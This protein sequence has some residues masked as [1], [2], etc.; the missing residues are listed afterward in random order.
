[1]PKTSL[2]KSHSKWSNFKLTA[3]SVLTSFFSCAIWI[4]LI[5]KENIKN[6]YLFYIPLILCVV[7]LI[8]TMTM[9]SKFKR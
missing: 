5:F 7:L 2:Q 1:M 9:F 6:E 8:L 4:V 3:L